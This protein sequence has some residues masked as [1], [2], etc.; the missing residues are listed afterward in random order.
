M[1]T[2]IAN[3]PGQYWYFYE[4]GEIVNDEKGLCLDIDGDSGK[5]G[6]DVDL[7]PCKAVLD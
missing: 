5:A 6:K 7:A 1:K 2:C 3:D 4:N